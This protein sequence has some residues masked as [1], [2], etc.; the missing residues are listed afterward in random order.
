VLCIFPVEEDFYRRAQVAVKYVG[1]PLVDELPIGL[2]RAEA[3]E[4]LGIG[5]GERALVLM[6][7]SRPSEFKRHIGL[8]LEGAVRA[9]ARLRAKGLL[10]MTERLRVLMPLPLTA[11]LTALSAAVGA[12][13][14]ATGADAILDVRVSTG[15]ADACLVAADAGL[16]KSGTST[17]EAALLGCPHAVVYRPSAL[18]A[19]IFK[20]LIRYRGPVGLVNLVLG[21]K[22]GDPYLATELLCDDATPTRLG[23]EAYS[24]LSDDGRRAKIREGFSRIR[25]LLGESAGPSRRA[26]A[27]VLSVASDA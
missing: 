12:R 15:D 6:V 25:S 24:L 20:W 10:G 11:D 27:E 23:D 14:G 22:T 21:W 16:I 2:T 13:I 1:N 19:W 7:G 26:A 5:E 18:T 9:A 8:M 3:R 17:L 4:R